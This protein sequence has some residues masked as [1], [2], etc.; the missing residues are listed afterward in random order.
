MELLPNENP[1][2]ADAEALL[3]KEMN[4]LSVEE[5][6]NVL[7]DIHGI[8]D[9]D[10][11]GDEQQK[12]P[13]HT[14]NELEVASTMMELE[15]SFSTCATNVSTREKS[16]DLT[17]LMQDMQKEIN[18]FFYKPAYNQALLQ[19]S[20]YVKDT[21]FFKVFKT[22]NRGQSIIIPYANYSFYLLNIIKTFHNLQSE[23]IV[24]SN[25]VHID[26]TIKTGKRNNIT[27]FFQD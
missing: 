4:Q 11:D 22:G 1:S 20:E 18:K 12:P 10:G 9:D 25:S 17:A 13:P 16:M 2:P 14:A 19:D 3:A 8:A 21:C 24:D 5:R 7:N 23:V 6:A 27:I 15:N 26:Q